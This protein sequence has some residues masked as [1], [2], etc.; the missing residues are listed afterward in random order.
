MSPRMFSGIKRTLLGLTCT[1]LLCGCAGLFGKPAPDY[2]EAVSGMEFSYVRGGTFE[3]GDSTEGHQR[4]LPVHTVAVD[5]FAVCMYEVTFSQFDRFCDATGR[6]KPDD[7]GWG[8]GDRPVINVSW[9][10]AN[11]Y[12]AWLSNET[13]LTFSLPSEAQ[14]EYFARAGSP[15]RY[16]TGATLPSE[17]ANCRECGSEWDDRMTAPVGSFSPNPWKVFDT[18]GNVAEWTLDDWQR[19]YDGAPVDGTARIVQGATHKVY[20]GGAWNYPMKGLKAST[21]D[22]ARPT[23]KFNEV[24]FRLVLNEVVIPAGK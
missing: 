9:E 16:W 10:E 22:W 1:T 2:V 15:D 23:E 21:R 13:G 17:T 14:W 11:A 5:D 19:G 18:A 12:A 7:L 6:E 8:R 20:R 4:E 24:G 3:M